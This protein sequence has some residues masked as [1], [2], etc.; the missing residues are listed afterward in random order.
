MKKIII[1]LT[2][3]VVLQSCSKNNSTE[4]VEDVQQENYITFFSGNVTLNDNTGLAKTVEIK[5]EV[6]NGDV[7]ETKEQSIITIQIAAGLLKI[8]EKSIYTFNVNRTDEKTEW[9]LTLDS[10]SIFSK[11][12]KLKKDQ[13]YII[14]T[15]SAIISVRG[16]EF[17]VTYDKESNRTEVS[18][19]QG[20][21]EVMNNQTNEIIQVEMGKTAVIQNEVIEVI[22][23]IENTQIITLLLKMLGLEEMVEEPGAQETAFF[24]SQN[25]AKYEKQEQYYKNKIE[26]LKLYEQVPAFIN[27][28]EKSRIEKRIEEFTEESTN[29]EEIRARL[30]L[31]QDMKKMSA[32]QR[33]RALGTS[34]IENFALTDGSQLVG[35]VVSQNAEIIYLDT[36]AGVIKLPKTDIV[37]RVDVQ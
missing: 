6:F 17:L 23:V 20:V 3:I 27:F 14:S 18:V 37:Q 30:L 34:R 19:G 2:F 36:G 7:I 22:E 31:Y 35:M 32:L 5:G 8:Q 25:R 10:G 28:V 11:L 29:F 26:L 16:T 13:S 9:E 15:P 1:L 12:Q 33:L 21:V 4:Q 24:L